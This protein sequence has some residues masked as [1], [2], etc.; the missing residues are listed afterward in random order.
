VINVYNGNFSCWEDVVKEFCGCRYNEELFEQSIK[1]IGKPT[2]VIY[3]IY[4]IDGYDGTAFVLWRK[5]RKYYL[6]RGAHCSCYGLE[7]AG[8]DPEEFKSKKEVLAYLNKV[9]YIFGVSKEVFDELKT[10]FG[11]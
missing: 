8:W 10:M 2:E 6:L 4:D 5:G 3:A 1:T 9:N 11:G 7:E